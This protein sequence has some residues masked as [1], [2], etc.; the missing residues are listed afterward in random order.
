MARSPIAPTTLLGVLLAVALPAG[1]CGLMQGLRPETRLT[2]QVNMLND[3]ARWGR[4]DLAAMRC[5]P[6][7]RV[8][9]VRSHRSWGRSLAIGDV[10]ITNIAMQQGGAQSLVTYAWIDQRTQELRTTTVRQTWVG[11]T[12]GFALAGEDVV[13][14]DDGLFIEVEG[15][16]QRLPNADDGLLIGDPGESEASV[17]ADGRGIGEREQTPGEQALAA[18]RPRRVDSQGRRID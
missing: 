14:G 11:G 9:F 5:A 2:D 1:G 6:T 3:E 17:S 7:Y 13:N 4:V 16:P 8:A 10:D 15:G 18:S 12:D